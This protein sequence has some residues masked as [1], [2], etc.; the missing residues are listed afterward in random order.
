MEPDRIVEIAQSVGR[1]IKEIETITGKP[2]RA[3]RYEPQDM[4]TGRTHVHVVFA[5]EDAAPT[6]ELDFIQLT[7]I[8]SGRIINVRRDSIID[9]SDDNQS[10]GV[11]NVVHING[12]LNVSENSTEILRRINGD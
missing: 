8:K 10:E 4:T 11:C 6:S 1:A 9:F 3:F 7:E 2:V 12:G 5:V